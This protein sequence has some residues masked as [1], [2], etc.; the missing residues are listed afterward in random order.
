MNN[1]TYLGKSLYSNKAILDNRKKPWYFAL[2][3]FILGVFLPWIPE[4]YRGYTQ[5]GSA[6]ITQQANCEIDK[7]LLMMSESLGFEQ[8][9]AVEGGQG[10]RLSMEGLGDAG[11]QEGNVNLE[12]SGYDEEHNGTNT[13]ALAKAYFEDGARI[14]A[15][16]NQGKSFP[17][18]PY[19]T[20]NNLQSG[21]AHSFYY[22]VMM[23]DEELIDPAEGNST[24]DGDI[25]YEDNGNTYFLMVYYVPTLDTSTS[26]GSK[27]LSNFVASVILD[28]NRDGTEAGNYPH[29]YIIF[30][31]NSVNVVTYPIR[32]SH[33][34]TYGT[35][36][37]GNFSDA[38]KTL[39]PTPGASLASLLR[40]DGTDSDSVLA[41]LRSFFNGGL[42]EN[43][44]YGTWLNVAILTGVY[45]GLV[46][47][48]SVILIILQKRKTSA[49]R[50]STY[51]DCLKESVAFAFT[52]AILSMGFGFLDFTYGV[53][54]LVLAVLFRI[55]WSNSKICPPN[56]QADN[57]P[58]Y[59][60]RS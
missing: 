24:T 18:S 41:N 58:L 38:V 12:A 49:Y 3:F 11:F 8:L 33:T 9:T 37:I 54:I 20:A 2:L 34:S 22:D 47:L 17:E 56:P 1:L 51:W 15:N 28:L 48:S 4:L 50:D 45:C 30:A 42:R 29:S 39:D 23:T 36:Y 27:Y 10:Y 14:G 43:T 32:S 7:G 16:D 53:G 55:I 26:T 31:Q 57:K 6:F 52:P 35:Q 59:Q 46:L 25:Q 21:E 13:Y 5:D 19:V 60:A 40:K 44:I